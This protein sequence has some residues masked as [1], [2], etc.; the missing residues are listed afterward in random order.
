MAQNEI[1]F[2]YLSKADYYRRLIALVEQTKP[3]DR[4]HIATML[5]FPNEPVISTLLQTLC[6]AA[7]RGVEVVLIVDYFAFLIKKGMVPGPL[8]CHKKLP[9]H[10]SK[11]FRHR[12]NALENLRQHGGT[13]VLINHP[14]RKFTNP[15]AGRSHVKY[16]LVNDTVF[17]GGCNLDADHL[18]DMMVGWEDKNTADWLCDFSQKLIVEPSVTDVF[19][20]ND[21]RRQLES[22]TTL[23]VDVGIPD[24]SAILDKALELIDNAKEHILITCQF[25]PFGITAQHLAAAHNRGVDVKV[26]YNHPHKPEHGFTASTLHKGVLRKQKRIMPGNFF[27]N[28]LPRMTDFLH[29][30]L[31]TSESESIIG[32]HNYLESGVHW[33]TAEIALYST[34]PAF[35]QSVTQAIQKQL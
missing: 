1:N 22:S 13:Y 6:V 33:G 23:Y 17:V 12:M 4:V 26:I 11:V 10:L 18:L 7:K 9:R 5:F 25:F 30:K 15:F 21:F 27:D 24:Q 14:K 35:K 8:F 19:G 20:K 34:D 31:L 28:Q 16:A 29:A 32:S 2:T 3:G